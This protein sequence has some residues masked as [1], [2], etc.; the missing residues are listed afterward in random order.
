MNSPADPVRVR[1][2]SVAGLL[3]TIPHLLG[4]TPEASLVVVGVTRADRVQAAFR[5]DL[6]SP[7]GAAAA[8]EIAGHAVSVLAR[9]RLPTVIAVGYG[10]G[11]LVTPLADALC[12]AAPGAGLWLRDV[13]RV[14]DHRYWSYLCTNP[15]CCPPEG[16]FFDPSS[17]PA[18][19]A[20]TAAGLPVLPG[21]DAV[22]AT[23]APV[24]GSAAQ[25][26]TD[27]TG[28]AER[29]ARLLDASGPQALEKAGL[30]AVSS[31]IGVYRDGG[32]LTPAISFAWLAL[33]LTRVRVRDDAWARMDP[34][35]R[36]R[37]AGCGPTWS[38]APGPATLPHPPP[39]SRSPPGK[40]ATGHWPTWRSTGRSMTPRG[41]RWPCCCVTH[42]TRASRRRRPYRR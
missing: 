36:R 39:C 10:P 31:A 38:A 2:S 25:A 3:A 15:G 18:S 21:R 33:V 6:P 4:F 35:T 42:S 28:R 40:A 34:G 5:Y 30:V 11:R 22:A 29:A 20:L 7:P 26:M 23:I 14:E 32:S 41:T 27:A 8:A 1:V 37:T 9:H 24:A 16:V 17:H 19:A 13:L 12:A